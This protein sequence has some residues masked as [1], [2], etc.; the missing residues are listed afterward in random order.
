MLH[1]FKSYMLMLI[2]LFCFG[3]SVFLVF[4]DENNDHGFN[5]CSFVVQT[6]E[7]SVVLGILGLGL[8][9]IK[10][11]GQKKIEEMM[12][13]HKGFVSWFVMALQ[14][15]VWHAWDVLGNG[16]CKAKKWINM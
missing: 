7:T 6:F 9:R 1:I 5:L 2:L 12:K 3:W 11:L 15:Q 13:I 4:I 16:H 14:S 10:W 8:Q